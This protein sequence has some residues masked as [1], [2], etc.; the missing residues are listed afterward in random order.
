MSQFVKSHGLGNDYLVL[1]PKTLPFEL[2]AEAVRLICDRH[3]GVGSDGVLAPDAADGADFG[4]RIFNPDGSEA[5]KS[6]NGVRI[7]AKYLREHGHTDRDRIR[8][9]TAGGIVAVRLEMDGDRVRGVT[10]D[11]GPAQFSDIDHLELGG[12][13][14]HVSVVSLGN[15]HCVVLVD[16]VAAVDVM[17]L[18]PLIERHPAFPD[19]TN[20]QFAQVRSRSEIAIRIWERGA[21]YTLA[22]GTSACAA[23]AV[24]ARAGLVDRDVGVVMPGGRLE[25]RIAPDAGIWLRGTVEEIAWGDFSPDLLRLLAGGRSA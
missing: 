14:V 12:G 24:A 10:A 21:G 7:F 19:R 25:V 20:V 2:T 3:K 11:M 8:I 5:E 23:A 4:L 1:D 6:G 15:P 16:D 18:G 17:R 9:R 22:S 13:H